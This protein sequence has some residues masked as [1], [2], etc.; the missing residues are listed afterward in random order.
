[1]NTIYEHRPE[2]LFIGG[3]TDYPVLMHVHAVAE[4]VVLTQGTALLTIDEVQYR[5][6]PGAAAAI[7]VIWEVKSDSPVL[8]L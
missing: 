4:L 8:P 3:M 1:M 7:L 5:L 6:T 2:K